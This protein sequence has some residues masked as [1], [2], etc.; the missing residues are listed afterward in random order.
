MDKLTV[1]H[2]TGLADETIVELLNLAAEHHDLEGGVNALLPPSKKTWGELLNMPQDKSSL[3]GL[4]QEALEEATRYKQS[5]PKQQKKAVKPHDHEILSHAI[6]NSTLGVLGGRDDLR[7]SLLEGKASAIRNPLT[8]RRI[9]W[10]YNYVLV[11]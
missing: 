10:L 2:A 1:E 9:D 3:D 5:L 4:K 7:D 11:L 8:K 6:H